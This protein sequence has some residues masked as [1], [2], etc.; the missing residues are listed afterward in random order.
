MGHFLSFVITKLWLC[1]GMGLGTH[2]PV[3]ART[4]A[5]EAELYSLASQGYPNAN[6]RSFAAILPPEMA[7]R[8]KALGMR[9]GKQGY[10]FILNELKNH[11]VCSFS[12]FVYHVK[13][14]PLSVLIC[15]T[16]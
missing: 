8:I 13:C 15:Y 7:E 11:E 6:L 3:S 2:L 4:L 1:I 5:C 10:R 16:S 12:P 9:P 14:L